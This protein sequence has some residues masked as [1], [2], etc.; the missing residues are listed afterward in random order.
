MAAV[1]AAPR[2]GSTRVVDRVRV[3]IGVEPLDVR[4]EARLA[5]EVEGQ[6]HAEAAVGSG[7]G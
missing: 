3:G 1:K 4:A 7:V 2:A 6:V 5:G